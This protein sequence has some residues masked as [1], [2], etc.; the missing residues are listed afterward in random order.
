MTVGL[1]KKTLIGAFLKKTNIY[2]KNNYIIK[3]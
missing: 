3:S 2:N 1:K